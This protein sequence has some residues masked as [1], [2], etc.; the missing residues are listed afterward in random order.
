VLL[1]AVVTPLIDRFKE[2]FPKRELYAI[3]AVKISYENFNKGKNYNAKGIV[4]ISF[5]SQE[6]L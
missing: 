6:I 4:S 2:E 1:L 5:G 3:V